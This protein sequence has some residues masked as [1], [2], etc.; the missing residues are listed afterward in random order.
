MVLNDVGSTYVRNLA[1]FDDG[2]A[3]QLTSWVGGTLVGSNY[4]SNVS[5]LG[6]GGGAFF[7]AV[8]DVTLAA[9]SFRQNWA[10]RGSG[11][12]MA[13][14]SRPTVTD[15]SFADHKAV[16]GLLL[17]LSSINLSVSS[18]SLSILLPLSLSTLYLLSRWLSLPLLFRPVVRQSLT[19]PHARS[20]PCTSVLL[21]AFSCGELTLQSCVSCVGG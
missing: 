6:S 13:S 11:L 19:H 8:V 2:G 15:T 3:V 9:S 12:A 4:T 21:S 18:L 14:Q 20:R 5:V 16:D 10:R 7:G 17:S 1:M